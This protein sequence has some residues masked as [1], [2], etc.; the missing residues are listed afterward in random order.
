VDLQTGQATATGGEANIVNVHGANSSGPGLYNLLIGNGGNVLTGGTGRRNLLVA[1]GAA[2]TLIGGTQEDLLIGGTTTYDTEA[3]LVSW[4][5]IAA[6]WAG[7]DP[8][9]T[10]VNNLEN[11]IGVPLLD[12]S[13]VT[14]NGGGNTMTGS[15]ELALI[16]TDGADT[17]TNFDPGS[18]TFPITP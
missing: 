13:I 11:G 8:F 7:A 15:L 5:A 9:S 4:Q 3:G 18:Q 12:G 6:Y 17:I 14:G 1:G 16:Y 10:R 2:S